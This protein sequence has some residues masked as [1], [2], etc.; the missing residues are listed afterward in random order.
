MSANM[1]EMGEVTV[2]GSDVTATV[3]SLSFGASY[4]FLLNPYTAA[5]HGPIYTTAT[6]STL[7]KNSVC[8]QINKLLWFLTVKCLKDL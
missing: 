6:G 8:S 5:G 7:G 1:S 4:Y 3:S 2:G